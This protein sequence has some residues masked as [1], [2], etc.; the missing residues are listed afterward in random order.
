MYHAAVNEEFVGKAIRDSCEARPVE[1]PN[2]E[3]KEE[4]DMIFEGGGRISRL[5]RLGTQR[6]EL[7]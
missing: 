7:I 1:E 2:S 4:K 5:R 3:E 6:G